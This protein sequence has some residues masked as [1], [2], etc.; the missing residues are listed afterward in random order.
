[1]P[2]WRLRGTAAPRENT[3]P[4]AVGR[5]CLPGGS[6]VHRQ[7]PSDQDASG[8]SFGPEELELLRQVVESGTLTATKGQMA[9]SLAQAFAHTVGARHASTCSSG[10]AALDPEPGDEIVTSPITDMGALTPLLFQGAV[11]AFADVDPHTGNTTAET[12]AERLSERTRGIVVTHLF[13]NPCDMGPILSLAEQH[14]IPVVEDCAQA[15][16]ATSGGKTV[17]TLGSIG[18]FSLQQGKHITTG[19]GGLV[20]TDDD[21]L[22][23]RMQ[24]FIDKGWGYGDPEPDHYFLAPNYRMSELQ[25]AVALAQLDKLEASVSQ[26]IEMATRLTKALAGMPGIEAPVVHPENRHV[27]WRYVVRVRSDVIPGGSVALAKAL[28][29]HDVAAAPR[30][31]QKPAFRCAVFAEQR[32]FGTSRY[33]FTLARPE[34]VDY[35]AERFPGTFAA[36]DAMLVLPWNERYEPDH[37]DYLAEALNDAVAEL[38]GGG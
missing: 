30:Y 31:I 36:L 19:E 1:M 4:A 25:G 5:S 38:T 12:I 27:Y 9:R 34:A 22:A 37:V 21:Q 33:P 28:R 32:T 8:R 29:G 24:L 35:A 7:L 15:Y 23:R 20:V 14:G 13:G 6:L 16:L 2:Q 11:P 17:G 26:R 10:M 18:C 3:A